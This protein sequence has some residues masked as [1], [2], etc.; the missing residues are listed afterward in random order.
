MNRPGILAP[1]EQ[2]GEEEQAWVKQREPGDPKQDH[3]D[4]RC[5]MMDADK[6]RVTVDRDR[7]ATMHL[8][9]GLDVIRGRSRHRS[10]FP[11]SR[12]ALSSSS[13]ETRLAPDTTWCRK[14]NA[15]KPPMATKPAYLNMPFHIS[16]IGLIFGS[17]GRLA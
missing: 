8:V 16:T 12:L 6:R 17:L 14:L 15:A 5:P 11:V 9:A 1:T 7:I 10:A 2:V 4:H 13:R 3:R